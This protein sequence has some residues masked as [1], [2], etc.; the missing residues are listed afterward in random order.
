M[1]RRPP[2]SERRVESV[3]D[4]RL[5]PY[6][7]QMAKYSVAWGGAEGAVLS[8][9]AFFSLA[10]VLEAGS[11]LEASILLVSNLYYKQGLQMLRN[12]L[13][14]VILHLHFVNRAHEFNAWRKGN[15]RTPP[16]RGKLLRELQSEGLL[17]PEL[18]ELAGSLYSD[19]NG[20]VHGAE[21]R[22]VHA[23]IFEGKQAAGIFNYQRFKEWTQYFERCV[24]VGIH[25]LRVSTNLWLS[26]RPHNKVFCDVC[27][28]DNL[29]EF[30]VDKSE[31]RSGFVSCTCRRCGTE[32]N[33]SVDWITKMGY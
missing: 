29:K 6:F 33:Y 28:N 15:Y 27:H 26:K 32:L 13:E 9:C 14:E 19:L 24:V 23:G 10:H 12:F 7:G 31:S 18:S 3:P 20:T 25:V 21:R 16:V 1:Q 22:L 4:F 5:D 17:T 2:A 30:A 8:E 11:E